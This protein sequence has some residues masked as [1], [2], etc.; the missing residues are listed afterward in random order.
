MDGVRVSP[1]VAVTTANCTLSEAVDEQER[2]R[3]MREGRGD[4]KYIDIYT[5]LK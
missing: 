1:G 2:E 3:K 4:E 5:Y